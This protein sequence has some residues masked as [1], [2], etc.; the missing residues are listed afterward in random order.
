MASQTNCFDLSTYL[1]F[2]KIEDEHYL[3]SKSLYNVNHDGYTLLKYIK[4]GF[5]EQNTAELSMFRSIITHNGDIVGCSPFKALPPIEFSFKSA[6]SGN[7]EIYSELIDGTMVNVYHCNG[8]WQLSTRS[9]ISGKGRF[10]TNSEMTFRTMFLECMNASSLEFEDLNTTL[11]YSFVIQHPENRI[12][13]VI[14]EPKLYLCA[15]FHCV[16]TT[17]SVVDFRKLKLHEGLVEYPKL[18]S[19]SDNDMEDLPYDFVGVN[20]ESDGYRCKFRNKKYE[21]VRKLRGNQGKIEYR[22]LELQ[23]DCQTE[24]FLTYYPEYNLLFS[25]LEGNC[26]SFTKQLHMF[27]IECFIQKVKPICEFPYEFRPHMVRLHCLYREV[28]RPENKVVTLAKVQE[29]FDKLECQQQ[30][31]VLNYSKYN[32]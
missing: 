7:D 26:K 3:R 15:V 22:F 10:Y 6:L 30:M 31:F 24:E 25:I 11:S 9:V 4:S 19:I 5:T 12:V 32:K 21:Y 14:D 2:S 23:K 13:K 29:Y 8:E 20:I 16:G 18:I 17:I 1:D 27:Y 28:L